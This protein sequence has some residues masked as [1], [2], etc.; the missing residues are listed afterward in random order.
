LHLA[1]TSGCKGIVQLLVRARAKLDPKMP[2][3]W[4][5]LH[6]AIQNGHQDVADYLSANGAN[7]NATTQF[8]LTPLH[9]A[10]WYGHH[11]IAADLLWRGA[12][13]CARDRCGRTPLHLACWAG[14]VG[15]TRLLVAHGASLCATDADGGTPLHDAAINNSAGCISVLADRG[16]PLNT[17]NK[18]GH[19]PLHE[20]TMHGSLAAAAELIRWGANVNHCT[21]YGCTSL[22]LAAAAGDLSIVSILVTDSSLDVNAATRDGNTPLHWAVWHGTD[23]VVEMLLKIGADGT[24]TDNGGNTPLHWAAFRGFTR[25]AECLLQHSKEPLWKRNEAGKSPI[26]L[27][28]DWSHYECC[29][30]LLSATT[31]EAFTPLVPQR[32]SGTGS[33]EG[34]E[35]EDRPIVSYGSTF[36]RAGQAHLKFG[37]RRIEQDEKRDSFRASAEWIESLKAPISLSDIPLGRFG[38]LRTLR[39]SLSGSRTHFA[40]SPGHAEPGEQGSQHSASGSG[41]DTP[42]PEGSTGSGVSRDGSRGGEGARLL[43]PLDPL[44]YLG[45]C[46]WRLSPDD[47]AIPQAGEGPAILGRGPWGPVFKGLMYDTDPVAVRKLPISSDLMHL[48]GVIE[49]LDHLHSLHHPA[50]VTFFGAAFL[51]DEVWVVSELIDGHSLASL[52][53]TGQAKWEPTVKQAALACARALNFLHRQRPAV[54]HGNICPATILLC[55]GSRG[56]SSQGGGGISPRP[57][58]AKLVGLKMLALENLAAQMRGHESSSGDERIDAGVSVP[59]SSLSPEVAEGGHPTPPSDLYCLGLVLQQTT[60]IGFSAGEDAAEGSADGTADSARPV[61]SIVD[62][63]TRLRLSDLIQWCLEPSPSKR[64]TAADV[65]RAL[66]KL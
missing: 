27:A 51:P 55:D 13:T 61:A 62:E 7:I 49:H 23:Q 33:T 66:Q 16:P 50:L 47:L 8:K 56:A 14:H 30:M 37:P 28:R 60:G 40:Q 2:G 17:R 3:G 48:V 38:G 15:L 39:S 46:P 32:L 5:P 6:L 58:E 11:G 41:Q 1:A 4:T 53:Q 10:V 54:V 52:V 20:A 12:R 65:V 43:S 26:D 45:T 63:S 59:A 24:L 29:A 36:Q 22:H 57:V 64:P 18:F 25:I 34:E 21:S 44:D 9:V 42:G 19:A 35:E 31:G